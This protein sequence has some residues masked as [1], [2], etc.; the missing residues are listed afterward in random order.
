MPRS[1]ELNN[2][3]A[4]QVVALV[5]END[6]GDVLLTQ[7]QKGKHLAGFWEFPGG[8]VERKESLVGALQ[9]EIKEEINYHLKHPKLLTS[10]IHQYP[11]KK[12][13]IHF[14]HC[15]D[16]AAK[17][18]PMEQQAMQWVHKSKLMSIKLPEANQK[19]IDLI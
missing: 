9:R 7:R 17:P 3:P 1:S 18:E 5:L 19:I 12:V 4:I 8:K 6:Q 10:V 13:A 15:H 14:Y 11:D 2:D 16:P